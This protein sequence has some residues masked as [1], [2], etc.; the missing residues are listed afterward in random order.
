[1]DTFLITGL[2]NPGSQ[3]QYTRHNAGWLALDYIAEQLNVK[4]NKIKF[5]ATYGET[6]FHGKKLIL[7]KPQ[8]FMN[9]SGQAVS[10]CASYYRCV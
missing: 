9:N 8:T 7:L 1:M 6:V 10:A 3:Y 5:K 4:T 2:G